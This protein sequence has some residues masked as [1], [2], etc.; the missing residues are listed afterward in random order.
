MRDIRIILSTAIAPTLWGTTYLVTT[1]F[2]PANRPLLAAAVRA[3]PAG[4]LLI[5]TVAALAGRAALPRRA[6]WWRS[7]L[8]GTLNIGLFFALL[9]IG[10]YRLPG[11]VAAVL[12]AVGPF[13]VAAFAFLLLRER[14]GGRALL[15]A[16]IGVAGVALLV[17]RSTI[18][19]DPLGLA[20]AAG[21]MLVMSLGTVLGRRWGTPEGFANRGTALLALT[22]WQLTAGG[23][24]L[25]PFVFAIEGAPP[26]LT[27]T[28]LAGYAYLTLIGTALAYLL[29]FRGVTTLAPTRV[30]VLALL[31][32]VVAAILGWA[33]LGQSLSGGQLAGAVAVLGAVLLGASRPRG[34]TQAPHGA[35]DRRQ[36]GLRRAL[37]RQN[38]LPSGSSR[39]CHCSCPV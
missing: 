37:S 3:L 4:I 36:S 12:G 5:A 16:L 28:N 24:V 34:E 18:A 19:L 23:L 2:L 29:W 1:E 25:L 14:P 30:T 15:G 7:A 38:S 9:F 21:G 32:P 17:L 26:A 22:G 13:V 11:G 20:A 10:A 8:L 33:A 39:T 27:T 35:A 6:W 31:S